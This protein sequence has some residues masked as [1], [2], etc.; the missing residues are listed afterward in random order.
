MAID[1]ADFASRADD[2]ALTA[3]AHIGELLYNKW[4]TQPAKE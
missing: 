2:A 1:Q 3:F 4:G